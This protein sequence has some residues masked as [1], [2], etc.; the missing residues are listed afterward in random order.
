MNGQEL[1][2]MFGLS[3]EQVERDVERMESETENHG[4]VGPVIFPVQVGR[5]SLGQTREVGDGVP[6]EG[7]ARNPAPSNHPAKHHETQTHGT[8]PCRLGR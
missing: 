4:I 1:L 5:T 2:A 8:R 3:E 7:S 6:S